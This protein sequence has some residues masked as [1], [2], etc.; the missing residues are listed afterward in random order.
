MARAEVA[1]ESR[2]V[3]ERGTGREGGG[4]WF[5]SSGRLGSTED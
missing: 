1:I 4:D 5:G 3:G 2:G